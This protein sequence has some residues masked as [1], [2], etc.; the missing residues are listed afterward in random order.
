[1]QARMKKG[2]TVAMWVWIIGGIAAGVL[3]FTVAYANLSQVGIQT[4]R[5]SVV[6]QFNSIKGKADLL[7][8]QS[9]GARKSAEVSLR[10]VR[11]IYAA[12]NNSL[13]GSK[14]PKYISEGRVSTGDSL[15]LSFVDSHYD[16]K[17]V[18]CPVNM[19]WIGRPLPG[20]D[21]YELGKGDGQ[22]QF[23]LQM[24]KTGAGRVLIE[25][26]HIP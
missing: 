13:P 3:T 20:S 21:M 22:F 23:D 24:R 15:C 9:P 12:S 14:A 4:S 16:C 7:C 8:L 19:T 5:Q 26:R 17:E 18:R 25:A 10:D 2:G 1:M 6:E 11:A